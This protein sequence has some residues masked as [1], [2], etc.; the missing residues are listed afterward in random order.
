MKVPSDL[1]EGIV[2]VRHDWDSPANRPELHRQ[3]RELASDVQGHPTGALELIPEIAALIDLKVR[4]PGVKRNLP[5]C[6]GQRDY[7]HTRQRQPHQ[8]GDLFDRPDLQLQGE[9]A[10]QFLRRHIRRAAST[11]TA[12]L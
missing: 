4:E 7:G 2:A 9:P 3:S 10:A 12:L 1:A 11:N 8:V 6:D 5:R